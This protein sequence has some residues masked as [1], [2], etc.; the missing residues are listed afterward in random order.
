MNNGQSEVTELL[1]A[2]RPGDDVTGRLVPHVYTELRRLARDVRHGEQRH[3]TLDTSALVHEAYLKLADPER[4]SWD[5]RAHFFGA[6]ARAMRQVLVDH[7]RTRNRL[8]RGAGV[9]PQSLDDVG[10]VAGAL[11]TD[12]ALLDLDDALNR[13]DA[14]DPR[15]CRVVECRYFAGM[16]VEETAA[17]LDISPATVKREWTTARAWLYRQLAPP[18]A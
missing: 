17:A 13:L 7:A 2:R 16:T 9:R 15:Q 10:T 8:K 11:P 14:L 6:A 3:Q 18:E 1:A 5:G 12:H 4:T